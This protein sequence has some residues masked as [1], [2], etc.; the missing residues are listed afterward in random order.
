MIVRALAGVTQLARRATRDPEDAR[1]RDRD[2]ILSDETP[3]ED[4]AELSPAE[5]ERELERGEAG[6]R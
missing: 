5:K 4:F 3:E 6:S 2:R 1:G